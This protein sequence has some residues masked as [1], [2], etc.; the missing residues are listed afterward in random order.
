MARSDRLAGI[1]PASPGTIRE[2]ARRCRA[3]EL[4]VVPTETVYGLAAHPEAPGALARLQAAKGREPTKHLARL[5]ADA[6]AIRATGI[7]LEPAA[8]RLAAA[9]WPGPLTLVLPDG[10]GGWEGFRVPDHPVT[11]A[12]LRELD[13]LPVVTSANRSGEPPALTAAEA[14]RSLTPHVALALDA[15]PAPGGR[16]STVARVTGDGVEVLREGPISA[17]ELARVAD[18]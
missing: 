17:E 7:Q 4:V 13:V 11:L 9:F 12:W 3:G 18:G 16:A 15:G 6:D 8:L 1:V 2:A 14:W 5:A 10:A